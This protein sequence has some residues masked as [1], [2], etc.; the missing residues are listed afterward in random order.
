MHYSYFR[1]DASSNA[2]VFQSDVETTYASIIWIVFNNVP[3]GFKARNC[4]SK[5][6]KAAVLVWV[7]ANDNQKNTLI[8]PVPSRKATTG[9]AAKNNNIS[10]G[11]DKPGKC[12]WYYL[13]C[14]FRLPPLAGCVVFFFFWQAGCSSI[15]ISLRRRRYSILNIEDQFEL[16]VTRHSSSRNEW[17]HN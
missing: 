1:E 7:E 16:R 15:R 11:E 6:K 4:S 5:W 3:L 8:V 14:S 17:R 13:V 9:C 12:L 2:T 10:K